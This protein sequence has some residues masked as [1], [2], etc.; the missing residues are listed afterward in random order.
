MQSSRPHCCDVT[1]V[2]RHDA[3]LM[4]SPDPQVERGGRQEETGEKKK[5][6]TELVLCLDNVTVRG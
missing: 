5:R 1:E 6:N 3:G 4:Y 2:H